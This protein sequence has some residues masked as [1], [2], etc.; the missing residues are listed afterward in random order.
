M[1]G[2]RA[3]ARRAN[4][5]RVMTVLQS[6]PLWDAEAELGLGFA[7]LLRAGASQMPCIVITGS[8][9]PTW[10]PMG[11]GT[12]PVGRRPAALRGAFPGLAGAAA[13]SACASPIEVR[14]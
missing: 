3:A 12:A 4:C 5:E 6:A 7:V 14:T 8:S 1:S 13:G 9:A 10:P 11:R 2:C